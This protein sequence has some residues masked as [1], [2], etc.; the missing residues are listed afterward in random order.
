MQPTWK[1]N[2]VN[3]NRPFRLEKIIMKYI[4]YARKSTEGDDRQVISIPSQVEKI[5]EMFPDKQIVKVIKESRSAYEVNREGFKEM[6]ELLDSGKAQGVIA[7]HPDR[8][9]RNEVDAAAF[10][11]RIRKG[12]IKEALFCS[13]TFDNSPEGMMML[14]MTMSQSQYSSSKL[15]KDVKRGNEK[16]IKMGWKPG[17]APTGYLNTPDLEKGSKMIKPDPERFEMVR[18]MWDLMLTGNYTVPQ[19]HTIITENW[20]FKTR[21]TRKQGGSCLSRTG[22]YGIFTNIFYTGMI[23]YNGELHQGKHKAMITMDEFDRVQVL[24]GRKDK[25]RPKT[26]DFT[27]RGPI[28]C[29][30]CGCLITAEVKTK[31][32]VSTGEVKAYIYYHCT[33]KKGVCTQSSSVLEAELQQQFYDYIEKITILPVFR[34]W[35]I[36]MLNKLNDKEIKDRSKIH[37][38]RSKDVLELQSQLDTLTKMRYRELIDD[39]EYLEQKK[40]LQLKLEASKSL[41][42]DTEARAE[43]W[44]ELSEKTFDFATYARIHFDEA[45]DIATKR[46]IFA[47][48]SPDFRLM[49]KRLDFEPYKWFVPI[50]KHYKPLEARYLKVRTKE[51]GSTKAKEA[52]MASLYKDWLRRPDSNRRPFR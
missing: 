18:N 48:V 15:S 39:S 22:L 20:K 13:Y 12:T 34:D 2:W 28:R 41:L 38:L 46:N 50:E 3:Q 26:H 31:N 40:E 23:S 9:S 52:E 17:W 5:K 49:N 7:W 47:Q 16:K 21:K 33:K 24:L 35:A 11:Y 37:E 8:L 51:F 45:K 4:L 1:L 43:K 32:I 10:C 30:E 25:P 27:F 6:L 29:L 42:R 14:Q 19:I 44:L 36:E